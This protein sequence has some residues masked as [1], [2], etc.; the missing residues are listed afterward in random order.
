MRAQA[1]KIISPIKLG[2]FNRT[3]KPRIKLPKR[4]QMHQIFLIKL[5]QTMFISQKTNFLAQIDHLFVQ[6][7]ST[8][9]KTQVSLLTAPVKFSLTKNKRLSQLKE[10]SVSV[11]KTKTRPRIR[12]TSQDLIQ[13]IWSHLELNPKHKRQSLISNVNASSL[14]LKTSLTRT[15]QCLKSTKAR[16]DA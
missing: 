5:D 9:T 2:I 1:G 8:R 7:G 3:S 4:Q 6:S 15:H 13:S 16:K 11:K 10:N 14:N 12:L